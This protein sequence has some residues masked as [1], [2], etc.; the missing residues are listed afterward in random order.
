MPLPSQQTQNCIYH[1]AFAFGT[2][3]HGQKLSA[4]VKLYTTYFEVNKIYV[5]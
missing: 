4:S 3:I 2:E 1:S 5:K